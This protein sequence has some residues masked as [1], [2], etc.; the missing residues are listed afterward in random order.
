MSH[1]RKVVF[2]IDGYFMNKRLQRFRT[3]QFNGPGIREYC[4]QHLR[5][6]DEL[7]RIFFYDSPPLELKG[8]NPLTGQLVDFG[9]TPVALA[10]RELLDS[11]RR[12]PQFALRLGKPSWA[13]RKWKI[14]SRAL[15]A[16]LSG[17][18]ELKSLKPREVMP[19]IRQKAVDMKIGLDI[20]TIALKHLATHMVLITC[21]AD[22]VPA[23]KV[24]R[25]EGMVVG[26]DPLWANPP[27]DL[28]EHVDWVSTRLPAP[29]SP[30]SRT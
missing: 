27:A 3:F 15:T 29:T 14:H 10:Q 21:D 12:T 2:I 4:L 20:S 6:E 9:S 18:R 8:H 25:R 1:Y 26:L 16:I 28:L 23:L 13:G 17:K 30:G 22:F 24:A 19:D 11:I 5:P 7:Y